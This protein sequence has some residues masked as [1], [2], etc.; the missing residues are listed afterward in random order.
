MTES[1]AKRH[2]AGM[3]A[4]SKTSSGIA[5]DQLQPDDGVIRQAQRPGHRHLIGA[6]QAS[7]ETEVI[8]VHAQQ[9]GQKL[10]RP[11]H[12]DRQHQPHRRKAHCSK[13]HAQPG[14]RSSRQLDRPPQS[15]TFADCRAARPQAGPPGRN[16]GRLPR[17]RPV[18]RRSAHFHA[19]GTPPAQPAPTERT[20]ARAVRLSRPKPGVSAPAPPSINALPAVPQSAAAPR[21]APS[22]PRPRH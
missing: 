2:G 3:A 13:Q 10:Q 14:R 1:V 18:R 16:A 5:T 22:P 9:R 7:A 21:P 19:P 11:R 12:P 20:A 8:N 6:L 15:P 4:A 17:R